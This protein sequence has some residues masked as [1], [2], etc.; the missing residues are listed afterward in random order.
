[1]PIV[2]LHLLEGYGS[3]E[4]RRL[5][6]ALTDAVRLVVPADPET[7]TVMI[8]GMRAD[9]YYRGRVRRNPAPARPDP[10]ILVKSFLQAM[11]RRDIHA[12]EAMLADGFAMHFPGTAPMGRLKELLEWAAARYRFVK[13]TYEGFDALQ[14][15]GPAAIVYCR[16]TLSGEWPDGT[17]FH[18]IRFI[19]RFEIVGGAI[20]RQDVW[21]DIA[22]TRAQA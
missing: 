13:K 11:E 6:E 1:M 15:P 5:G 17:A 8:H 16:G 21:N 7:V 14:S 10:A 2:E 18:G 4:K 20:T 9:G 12:A 3:D 22:E 19:D